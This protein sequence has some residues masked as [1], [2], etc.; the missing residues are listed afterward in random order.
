MGGDEHV[1]IARLIAGAGV[2][3]PEWLVPV[4]AKACDTLQWS[5]KK[6]AEYP[7]RQA[8]RKRLQTLQAAIECVRENI[9]DL[10]ISTILLA[11]DNQFHNQ[12]ETYHGLGDLAARVASAIAK[13]PV[14]KGRDKFFV[15][16]DGLAL[17]VNCAL[18]VCV[19]W[20]RV[21]GK[22]APNTNPGAQQAC[23]E[24]WAAAGG[25]SVERWGATKDGASVAVWRDHLRR[26]KK[27]AGSAETEFIQRSL[28]TG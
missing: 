19:I 2:E 16:P 22:W 7:G 12:N 11:G 1:R 17:Q 26:A 15:R 3:L 5:V 20:N 18:M 21:H 9:R 27:S 14:R 8:L 24:L 4:I 23:A 25:R 10:D 6:E 13:I 28:G